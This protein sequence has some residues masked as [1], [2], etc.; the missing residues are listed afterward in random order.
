M[1]AQ[2][3]SRRIAIA[4]AFAAMALAGCSSTKNSDDSSGGDDAMKRLKAAQNLMA[5][6]PGYHVK[7]TSSGTP[8]QESSLKSGEGDVVNSPKSF[9]G[10]VTANT[11]GNDIKADVVS[12][13]KESWVKPGFSPKYISVDLT[14]MGVPLPSSLFNASSGLPALPLLSK[15]MKKS[16]EKLVAGQKVTLFKGTVAGPAATKAMGFGRTRK[17]YTV[18]VGL[19]DKNEML[20][21]SI[22]GSF[23]DSADATYNL[24]MSK[25]GQKVTVSKPA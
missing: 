20:S 16:G 19:N 5:K 6:T 3:P 10:T 15:D 25:Y 22:N 23:F 8:D 2:L 4:G 7:L 11:G 12:I 24:E 18:E 9:K 17:D 14:D 1:T 21:M 13:E